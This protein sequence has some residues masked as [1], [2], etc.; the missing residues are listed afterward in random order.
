[1][2]VKE[3]NFPAAVPPPGNDAN[4]KNYPYLN[5]LAQGDLNPLFKASLATNSYQFEAGSDVDG[6]NRQKL[7]GQNDKRPPLS[8]FKQHFL[9]E[10]DKS[11]TTQAMAISTIKKLSLRAFKRWKI[12]P[13]IASH[14]SCRVP[15]NVTFG[16]AGR[17]LA[18]E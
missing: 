4:R 16:E 15:T 9:V 10:I 14:G 5:R 3:W 7:L 18:T 13:S 8:I 11:G 2:M 1:M 17:P 12:K 6:N